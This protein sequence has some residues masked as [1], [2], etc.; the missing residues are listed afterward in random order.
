MKER[1][2]VCMENKETR[3]THNANTCMAMVTNLCCVS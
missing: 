1:E 2:E 3:E